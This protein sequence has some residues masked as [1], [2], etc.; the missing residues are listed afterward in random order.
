MLIVLIWSLV[1]FYV[2]S[3]NIVIVINIYESIYIP[4][5]LIE[6]IYI[7]CKSVE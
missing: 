5:D 3:C 6:C 7:V 2:G 4:T 1:K